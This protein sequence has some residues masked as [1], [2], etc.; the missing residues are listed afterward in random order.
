MRGKAGRFSRFVPFDLSSV[1]GM[2]GWWDASDSSTLF[3]ATTGGSAVAADGSVARLEDKSGNG[4]HFT[5]TSSGIRPVRKTAVQNGLDA[6]RFSFSLLEANGSCLYVDL[7]PASA[8]TIFIVAK[9]TT[10]NTNSGDVYDNETVFS[11]S[12]GAQ[13]AFVLKSDDTVSA[14]GFNG[15]HTTATVA[16]VPGSWIVFSSWHNGS[17]IYAKVNEQASSSTSLGTRTFTSGQPFLG[18]NW[19][20]AYFDGDFGEMVT[21]SVALSDAD[22]LNVISHLMDKWGIS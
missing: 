2:T 14:Y 8:S 22:R 10:V 1:A 19:N 7:Q 11:E 5:Q 21:Y 12:S 17:S 13:G 4:R 18:R 3:D 16:Y 20:T 6:A 9:A 15:G